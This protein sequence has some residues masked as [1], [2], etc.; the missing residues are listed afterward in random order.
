MR[1]ALY[2]LNIAALTA[3]VFPAV[4][5]FDAVERSH[6]LS[7]IAQNTFF[8]LLFAGAAL[9]VVSGLALT[10]RRSPEPEL[11]IRLL[12]VGALLLTGAIGWAVGG[13]EAV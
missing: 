7:P 8:A 12:S 9:C 4:V 2:G 1:V 13:V 10:K 3:S 6:A 5:M 11:A